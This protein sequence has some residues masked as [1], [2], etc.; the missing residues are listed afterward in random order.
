MAACK[1]MLDAAHGVPLAQHGH[2]DGAQR[3]RVRHPRERH[4]RR[5]GSPR[6]RRSSTVSTSPATRSPT[7]RRISATARSPRPPASAASRWRRRRRSSSSSAARPDDAIAN[8]LQMSHI[9]LG[10]NGAFTLPAMDFAGTPAGID[11]GAWS[12]PASARSSTPAS[13]TGSGRRPDRRRHHA[14]AARLL[15]EGDLR[16]G[17]GATAGSRSMTMADSPKLAVVAVGGNS[18]IRDKDHLSIPDQ[19]AQAAI[20]ARHIADMIEAG[21]NVVVT[22][23]NGPQMGFILR[24][25]ELSIHEVRAGADG[26][27][28]RRPAGRDRLHVRQ[29][30]PQRVPA[31]R[32]SAPARRGGD[33]DAGRP[34][35]SRLHGSDQADRLAYGRRTSQGTRRKAGLDREGGRRPR[36]AAR[37][38][39]A[40]AEEDRRSRRD[41]DSGRRRLRRHRPAAAAASRSSRMATATCAASR[42]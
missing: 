32:N 34:R 33:R 39:V 15:R 21:W 41:Q 3:R 10:R 14:R 2:R 27:R 16:A 1:A 35:R 25:S 22:H 26:L 28:R 17:G 4:R 23:G 31:P 20:T 6:P 42:R 38:A 36:L 30:V 37:R 13:R 19:Y 40:G 7:R 9:T 12:T 29:G 8:T 24:R 11:A 5:G 18:L